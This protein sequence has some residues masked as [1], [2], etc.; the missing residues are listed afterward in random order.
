MRVACENDSAT[1]EDDVWSRLD[2]TIDGIHSDVT[3]NRHRHMAQLLV[4]LTQ[5]LERRSIPS[6]SK[7]RD[8]AQLRA[9]STETRWHDDGPDA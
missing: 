6:L 3:D 1:D 4:E 5:C 8:L 2:H 7:V 9:V